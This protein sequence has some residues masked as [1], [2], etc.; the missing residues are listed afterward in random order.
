V[1]RLRDTI[2]VIRS[3]LEGNEVDI[4]SATV[5]VSHSKMV[6]PVSPVPIAIGSRSAQVMRLAG[7]L[8]DRA[9]VG[10]RYLSA[11]IADQYRTWVAEG[12]A[13]VGRPPSQVELAPRLTLCV[14]PDGDLAR[15]SV[16]RYVAHYV[17]L[18]RPADLALDAAWLAQVEA[19]L[20]RSRGW[21]FD[22][23]R[24]DDPEIDALVDDDLVRRFAVAGT[25]AEC[26]VLASQVLALGF[27]SASFNLAAPM[28]RSLYEG[29]RET[30]EGSGEVLD[31]LR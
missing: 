27:T 13:R 14:S 17:A 23:D 9:L 19:A 18:I 10:G 11:P 6:G 30:L 16:K 3:L 21:Y 1:A 7:E 4:A 26:V 31:G 20:A 2:G 8:A 22:L 28:R 5:T 12:A 29:L 25:P 15:R 24:Y